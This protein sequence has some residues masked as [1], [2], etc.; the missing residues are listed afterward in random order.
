MRQASLHDIEGRG[1]CAGEYIMVAEG[2][3]L[4]FSV[5]APFSNYVNGTRLYKVFSSALLDQKLIGQL[6]ESASVVAKH[7]WKAY[8]R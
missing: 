7:S 4:P 1:V 2:A 5:V 6:F 8:P 3:S